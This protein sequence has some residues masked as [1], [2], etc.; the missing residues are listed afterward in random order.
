M[1]FVS[2]KFFLALASAA[3]L[4][5]GCTKKPLRP[6]PSAT[7][8]GPQSGGAGGLNPEGV[9]TNPDAMSGLQ[10]RDANGAFDQNGQLRD[11]LGDPVYFD[12]DQSAI[13]ASER[14]K[15][16]ATKDYLDKNPQTRVLLE[17]H[18]D[19]RG[20]AEYNLALGDRRANAAKK[21]LVSLGVGADKI[22]TVSKGNEEA[23]KGDAAAIAKD[24]RVDLVVLKA[25]GSEPS[26]TPASTTTPAM[27]TP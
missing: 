16:Q 3:V 20:T 18:C 21:Y 7:L 9:A 12:T 6:D 22:E 25:E 5:A 13:K 15:L 14:S 24:R 11:A 10:T 2:P 23:K 4:L 1:K 19:W 27:P 26:P 8:M 17:G